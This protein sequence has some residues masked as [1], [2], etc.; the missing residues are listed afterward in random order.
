LEFKSTDPF[1]LS[2]LALGQQFIEFNYHDSIISLRFEE[3]LLHMKYGIVGYGP[4]SKAIKFAIGGQME[5]TT[6]FDP[7]PEAQKLAGKNH[8]IIAENYEE[9]VSSDLDA[10]IIASPPQFH[11]DQTIKAL[12]A[13][14]HVFAE[15][16]MVIKEEDIRKIII[17][18]EENPKAKYMLGENNCYDPDVL[19]AQY[20]SSTGKIGPIVYAEQEYIHDVS[21]RWRGRNVLDYKNSPKHENWYS[22]FDPLAYA[23]TILPAQVAMGGLKSPMKFIETQSYATD[24]GGED[25]Q[26]VCAPAKAFHVA[27]F[28]STT[29]AICKCIAAYVYA[30]SPTRYTSMVVGRFG[31]FESMG[32]GWERAYLYLADGFNIESGHRKGKKISMNRWGR[33]IKFLKEQKYNVFSQNKR[34]L[35][36]F[37]ASIKEDRLPVLNS[38]AVANAAMAG[39]ASSKAARSGKP[40][41]IDLFED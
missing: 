22:I 29:G 30:R 25:G 13:G 17:A 20:L 9:M 28:K 24:N 23:H 34:L 6:I 7:N 18:D 37:M 26:P 3:K 41:A 10:I 39:L 11:A 36:E 33:L 27:L 21:Y 2:I 40:E 4:R 31:S 14:K 5:L 15:V 19:Y 38:R 12:E 8:L 35:D 32:H 16:P 1:Y